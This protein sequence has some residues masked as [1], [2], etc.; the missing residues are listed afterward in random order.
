MMVG[1]TDWDSKSSDKQ[2]NSVYT[3][4]VQPIGCADGLDVGYE[5]KEKN[6]KNDT[7]V[8]S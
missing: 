4:K 2:L 7:K 8:L 6:V 5:K 3:L 1:P